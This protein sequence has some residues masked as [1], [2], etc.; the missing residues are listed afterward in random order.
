[1]DLSKFDSNALREGL[2]LTL[3]EGF[4]EVVKGAEAD[5]DLFAR[6][7]SSDLMDA[8][9]SGDEEA[10][11][12]IGDQIKVL[13]EINRV[14]CVGFAWKTAE[15]IARVAAKALETALKAAL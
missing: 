2:S 11:E 10:Y 14:R 8:I 4:A 5:L 15:R 1:M 13:A 3:K 7:L 6:A 9:E 12:Q